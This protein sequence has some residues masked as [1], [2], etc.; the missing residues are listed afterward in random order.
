MTHN[1][2]AFNLFLFDFD[3]L[4]VNTEEMHLEAYRQACRE[5]NLSL[6]WNFDDFCRHAHYS[7]TGMREGLSQ[8]FPELGTNDPLW[9][10]LYQS[11]TDKYLSSLNA[12]HVALLPGVEPF[13]EWLLARGVTIC[14]VTHSRKEM[15]ESIK[16]HHPILQKIPYWITRE[17]YTEAKPSPDGYLT[18]I[19]NYL[20]PGEKVIGFEDSPRGLE[21]LLGSGAQAVW[22][23]QVNYPEIPSRSEE[24]VWV[25]PNF[26][27][28]LQDISL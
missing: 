1:L 6:F 19:R 15:I 10:S 21:A 20:K 23:T 16:R 25:Y 3:G 22:V 2:K 24:G 7:A 27:K 17:D 26:E 11:K 9:N 4:L 12:G 18:A 13:L 8:L 14:V 5:K 28:I